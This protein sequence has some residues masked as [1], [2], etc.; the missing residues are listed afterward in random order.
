EG[1][2]GT[3]AGT[4]KQIDAVLAYLRSDTRLS[5]LSDK[6]SSC[7][8]MP[9]LRM[10]VK[11]KKEIV[12]IGLAEISPTKKVGQYVEATDWNQLISDPDVLLIDTRNGYEVDIGTYK[13]AINPHTD[14]FREFPNYV[15]KSLNV[16]KSKKIAMFCTGGIRCEKASSLMLEYG[17][18]EI[19]H[20]KGGI[21]KYLETVNEKDSLWQGECFVFDQRVSVKH[22]LQHG[23][24]QQCYGC[25]HPIDVVDMASPHYKKG[26]HCPHCINAITDKKRG[27]FAQRQL[28]IDLARARNEKHIARYYQR[29]H[30]VKEEPQTTPTTAH[31][32]AA[33]KK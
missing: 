8:E 4:E 15:N 1:I 22:D 28:Q 26:I 19:Y 6:R 14:N 16:N 25:R 27:R 13:G 5:D 9:F 18:K 32:I 12:S 29:H 23:T 10:K 17:F 3:I 11:L 31:A 2:N 7:D 21:L 33:A 30:T 24:Y 20:L